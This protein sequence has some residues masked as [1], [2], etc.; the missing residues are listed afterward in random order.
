MIGKELEMEELE[1]YLVVFKVH[2]KAMCSYTPT[3]Y[4]GEMIYF[5]ATE[6]LEKDQKGSKWQWEKVAEEG[7]KVFKIAGNH[8]SMNSSLQ[9][10]GY[11]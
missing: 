7:L 11:F 5:E 4:S 10:Y 2:S 6:H 8:I 3:I 9:C 1:K